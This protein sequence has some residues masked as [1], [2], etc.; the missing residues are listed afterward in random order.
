MNRTNKNLKYASKRG[1][2]LVEI[3]LV[4]AI[5]GMLVTLVGVAV[6]RYLEG[7]RKDAARAQIKSL[8]MACEAYNMQKGHYPA[9]LD[10][11][12]EFM[13]GNVIPQDPWKGEYQYSVTTSH[14]GYGYEISCTAHDGTTIAN[15]NT[16]A[17]EDAASGGNP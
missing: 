2:T 12:K 8:G 4:V 1:F 16:G 6:P 10:A 11:A 17:R 3:L 7:A 13:Q 5:I 15:W 14:P 9:T